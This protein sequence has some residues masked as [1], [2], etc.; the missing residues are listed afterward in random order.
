MPGDIATLLGLRVP[1]HHV[2]LVPLDAD[3]LRR[4]APGVVRNM[5]TYERQ[6]E[7]PAPGGLFDEGI[8]GEGASL[9]P[10]SWKEDEIVQGARSTQFGRI[11]LCEPNLH[12]LLEAPFAALP[13]L[14]P[15]LR[16]IVHHGGAFLMADLNSLYQDVIKSNARLQR[17]KEL[18][19]NAVLLAETRAALTRAIAAVIDNETQ[20][21][22]T[23][24]EQGRPLGSLRG[25][26]RPSLQAALEAVDDA[27]GKGFDPGAPLPLR[28]HRCVAVL[29][30]MGIVVR[31]LSCFN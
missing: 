17:L 15:D 13:V 2:F 3:T 16:P 14:P 1:L 29:F 21:H 6:T 26:L 19:A 7:R 12:P 25:M 4:Q 10:S 22:P 28:L 24:D 30:A 5:M 11:E 27:V 18:D 8:F 20:P 23:V 9:R 31:P